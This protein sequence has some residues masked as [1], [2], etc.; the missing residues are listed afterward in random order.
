MNSEPCFDVPTA[1]IRFLVQIGGR[2]IVCHVT[3]GW[4]Y[5]QFGPMRLR[6][7]LLDAYRRNV[8][9]IEAAAAKRWNASGGTE[10]VWLVKD[11]AAAAPAKHRAPGDPAERPRVHPGG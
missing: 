9:R 10:P 3:E 8:R 6:W 7:G 2:A 4:M 11:Q 1:S 5:D